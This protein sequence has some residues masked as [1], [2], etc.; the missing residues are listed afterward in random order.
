M[1][2]GARS[3]WRHHCGLTVVTVLA[4]SVR[5]LRWWLTALDGVVNLGAKV[6][7]EVEQQVGG[8]LGR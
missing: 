2:A 8:L 1:G 6:T 3:W 5:Q 7:P 4:W